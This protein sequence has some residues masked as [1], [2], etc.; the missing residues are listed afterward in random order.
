MLFQT[1]K[2]VPDVY[3]DESRDFQLLGNIFDIVFNA[4][5]NNMS[6]LDY[7]RFVSLLDAS[8]LQPMATYLG[9]F[10]TLYYPEDL[11]RSILLNFREIVKY[12]GTE[13][14]FKIAIESLQ[15]A[16]RGISELSVKRGDDGYTILISSDGV[17]IDQRY[18]DD[19][20][21]YVCPVGCFI[22]SEV[23][24]KKSTHARSSVPIYNDLKITKQVGGNLI[25]SDSQTLYNLTF[26]GDTVSGITEVS[27]DTFNTLK[28][29]NS[30]VNYTPII[31]AYKSGMSTIETIK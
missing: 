22:R 26:N 3:I 30:R 31:S 16:Y 25:R 19:L 24:N 18:I 5:I 4:N 2:N 10:T 27:E 12:K 17:I 28:D 6:K 21:R 11:M 15:N 23:F 14:G 20:L 7:L 13:K 8:L 29:L 9:F 1:K